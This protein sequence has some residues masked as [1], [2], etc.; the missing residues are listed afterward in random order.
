MNHPVSHLDDCHLMHYTLQLSLYMY[1]IIKHNPRLSPGKL[2]IHHILFEEAGRD[3]YDNP[4][5][6]LDTNGDPIVKDVI[7]Y[8][9]PYLKQEIISIINWWKDNNQDVKRKS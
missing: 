6:A 5:T 7:P 4:I 3:Q 1:I 8:E 2:T 9:L